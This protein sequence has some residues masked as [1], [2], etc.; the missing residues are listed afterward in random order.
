MAGAQPSCGGVVCRVMQQEHGRV[1]G[2]GMNPKQLATARDGGSAVF[3]TL[4][5]DPSTIERFCCGDGV[6]VL[7]EFEKRGGRDTY[8]YCPVWQAE[9]ERVADGRRELKGGGVQEPEAVASWDDGRMREDADRLVERLYGE[10]GE[11]GLR[12]TASSQESADPWAQARRD[13]DL[14]AEGSY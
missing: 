2:L 10:D 5:G 8:T 9:K 14:L 3:M 11:S 6:P 12:G 1:D 4:T 13:V 7:D